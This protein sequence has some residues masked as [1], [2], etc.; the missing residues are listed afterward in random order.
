ME[1]TEGYSPFISRFYLT[2]YPA[3]YLPKTHGIG[4]VLRKP[5]AYLP[6]LEERL[7]DNTNK[8]TVDL[9]KHQSV[10]DPH[11]HLHLEK[12]EE[13]NPIAS[14]VPLSEKA[15][16]NIEKETDLKRKSPEKINLIYFKRPKF[17]LSRQSRYKLR[18]TPENFK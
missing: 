5:L 14:A 1:L 17:E 16:N 18:V 8:I 15:E 10:A 12:K 9:N 7:E 4:G 3:L 13:E 6:Y 11:E 2:N